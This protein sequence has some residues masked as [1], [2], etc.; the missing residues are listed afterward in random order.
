MTVGFG[1]R[2]VDREVESV[3]AVVVVAAV[4]AVVAVVVIVVL[5]QAPEEVVVVVVE[6]PQLL[7][8]WRL[9]LEGLSARHLLQ[10]VLPEDG[11]DL[12]RQQQQF[13]IREKHAEFEE[14]HLFVGQSNLASKEN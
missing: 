3:V 11:L 10:Q 14:V 12:L 8:D 5:L 13:L 1:Q 9:H 6:V 4:V 2:L 7:G